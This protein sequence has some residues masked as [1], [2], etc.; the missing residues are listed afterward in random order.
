[1]ASDILGRVLV[2]VIIIDYFLHKTLSYKIIDDGLY[3][4]R[5][6]GVDLPDL[7]EILII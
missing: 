3:E 2:S 6:E 7:L 4:G 5:D 1:V